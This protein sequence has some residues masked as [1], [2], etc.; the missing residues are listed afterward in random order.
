MEKN[1]VSY[2]LSGFSGLELEENQ[3]F[4]IENNPYI[5]SIKLNDKL[6]SITLYLK[7]DVSFQDNQNAIESFLD[8]II[9]N[10]IIK[11]QVDIDFPNWYLEFVSKKD[12]NKSTV[13]ERLGI[14]DTIKIKRVQNA[15]Y[16][17][18]DIVESPTAI[19]INRLLYERI[20]CILLNPNQVVQFMSLY[21]ILL[22]KV[23]NIMK[24]GEGQE[25]V[26]NYLRINKEKY[27][28]IEFQSSSKL[29]K[30]GKPEDTFTYIRNTIAHCENKDDFDEYMK[31]GSSIT[32]RM[33]KN[34]LLVLNDVIM[35]LP[36][37]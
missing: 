21:E 32:S 16:I 8:G 11:T 14:R 7:S 24:N 25:K 3:S 34:L 36:E 28:F 17:Y 12:A 4:E 22:D 1:Y 13:Y 30:N 27:P 37:E 20:F 26:V 31:V 6:S 18:K 10:L 29:S 23:Q 35:D 5:E 9:F 15:H 19:G 33:I 2:K